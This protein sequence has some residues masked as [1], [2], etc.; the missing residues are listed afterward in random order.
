MKYTEAVEGIRSS[1]IGFG[2]A[3]VMGSRGAAQSASALNYAIDKGVN[4][5]DL[6][7]SYGY[8]EAERFIG[9]HIRGK[10]HELVL[11]SKFGIIAN[12]RASL[13]RPFKPILRAIRPEKRTPEN[14]PVAGSKGLSDMF[15]D[16]IAIN[17][18]S[19]R[20]SLEQSLKALRTDYLDYFF[21]HEPR[22]SILQPDEIFELAEELR[23]AG[24]I[25]AF[26]LAFM[27]DQE[28][29]HTDYLNSFD[30]LQFNL[31]PGA[32]A[33]NDVIQKRAGHGNIFFSPLSNR[34]DNMPAG[35]KL[36]KLHED[37]PKSVILCSMF[38]LKH[39]DENT[40]LF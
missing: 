22:G 17:S 34:N 29:F 4:H 26:G 35:E 19:M 33:Y 15:H 21:V 36:I 8:G 38:N 2:C 25:R 5:L 18:S 31:S 3:P 1:V 14:A 11:S 40:S 39:I 20:S 37:F 12:W 7:R 10:R 16:R 30:I 23:K 27:R 6:A 32:E 24:K 9:K 13:I 28:S